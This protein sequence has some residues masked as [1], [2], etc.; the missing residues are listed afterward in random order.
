[1]EMG[2]EDK[3]FELNMKKWFWNTFIIRIKISIILGFHGWFVVTF[4]ISYLK[5]DHQSISTTAMSVICSHIVKL[6]SSILIFSVIRPLGSSVLINF[7]WSYPDSQNSILEIGRVL[8][9]RKQLYACL[10]VLYEFDHTTDKI[11]TIF[12]LTLH[13]KNTCFYYLDCHTYTP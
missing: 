5:L 3:V 8:C 13:H 9:N 6:L 4:H 1:M 2:A 11:Q 12:S 7:L 10:G